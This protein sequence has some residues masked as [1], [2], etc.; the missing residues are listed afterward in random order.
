MQ[1]VG[2]FLAEM[3]AFLETDR[4][5]QPRGFKIEGGGGSLGPMSTRFGQVCDP[6][7]RIAWAI[8][9]RLDQRSRNAIT[10]IYF[11]NKISFN[12]FLLF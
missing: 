7:R 8:P 10:A 5:P 9:P 4:Q 2:H 1:F 12:I 11:L 3:V 6:L